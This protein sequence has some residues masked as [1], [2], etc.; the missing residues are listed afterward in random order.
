MAFSWYPILIS[1]GAASFRRSR[2]KLNSIHYTT[3]PVPFQAK[4]R[5]FFGGLPPAMTERR[6]A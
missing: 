6:L 1:G 2:L 3:Y 4:P 5:S